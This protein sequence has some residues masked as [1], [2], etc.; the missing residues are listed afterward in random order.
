DYTVNNHAI[1]KV[2]FFRNDISNLIESYNLPFNKTNNQSIYSYKNLDR[3]F[4]E[5]MEASFTY[6]FNQ[7]F[8]IFGGYQYLIAKDKEIL[9]K[10]KN[11]ELYKRDPVT[12]NTTLVT[13]NDYKGLYNR[14]RN[15]ANLRFQ[16]HNILYKATAFITAKY[17]GSY[18]Y[19]G[20]NGF[21]NGSGVYDDGRESVNGFVL[22]NTTLSKQFASRWEVQT[23]IENI[24]NYTNKLLM[25]NIYGRSYFI[26][27][28]FKLEK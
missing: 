23:G 17:R 2:N 6:N 1:I 18:G 16:Y 5:G 10:I 8:S 27:L 21:Q 25:P 20:L 24:F 3:V 4:T 11:G 22:L 12:Y 28:N 15:N 26:N 14:S 13:K 7:H 19:S 9:K